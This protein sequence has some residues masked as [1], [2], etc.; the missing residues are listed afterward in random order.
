MIADFKIRFAI[1]MMVGGELTVDRT[2]LKT[3][4]ECGSVI[5]CHA[6]LQF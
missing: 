3:D 2:G 5:I 4:N 6:K 1:E